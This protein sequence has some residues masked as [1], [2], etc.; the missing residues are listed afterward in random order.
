MYKPR[1]LQNIGG[2]LLTLYEP[3]FAGI[4]SPTWVEKK[5]VE[6]NA[7]VYCLKKYFLKKYV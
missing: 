3:H 6:S 1:K 7:K 4:T 2:Q 5:L